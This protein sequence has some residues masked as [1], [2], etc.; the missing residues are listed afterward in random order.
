MF[1]FNIKLFN[2]LQTRQISTSTVCLSVECFPYKIVVDA[3]L[4]NE[5]T[6]KPLK[7]S[8]SWSIVNKSYT[9]TSWHSTEMFYFL[10]CLMN[11]TSTSWY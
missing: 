4:F 5:A 1:L 7:M 10:L 11:I 2:N 3:E 8:F 9:V 6:A